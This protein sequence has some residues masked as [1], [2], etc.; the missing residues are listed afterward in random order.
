M[1][2]KGFTLIE[3]L[4]ATVIIVIAV[5]GATALEKTNI[6]SGSYSKHAIE[7]KNLSIRASDL[8]KQKSDLAKQ[9]GSLE[10]DPAD[11]DDFRSGLYFF[12]DI[13][14]LKSCNACVDKSDIPVP[15]PTSNLNSTTVI[16][17]EG[18]KIIG[19]KEFYTTIIVPDY[20]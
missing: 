6:E 15:C 16:C 12:D 8:V 18:V 13:G 17:K 2:K 4:I 20:D 10:S 9:E 11:T 5:V 7:A 1:K 19:G 14:V 3:V